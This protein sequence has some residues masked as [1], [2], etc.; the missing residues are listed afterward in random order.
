MT[1]SN[2]NIQVIFIV[3]N[4]TGYKEIKDSMTINKI[5][6]VGVSPKPPDFK[7]QAQS[8]NLL[9]YL[10]ENKHN[11]IKILN[12]AFEKKMSAIVEISE[13]TY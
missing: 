8:Y 11:L 3:W 13:I 2:E 10:V 12:I 5:S 1:T 9:Y 4:N 7:L 6:P